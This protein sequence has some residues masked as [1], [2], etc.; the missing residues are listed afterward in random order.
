MTRLRVF[1]VALNESLQRY[2]AR[3]TEEALGIA[4]A[5]YFK[6]FSKFPHLLNPIAS[7]SVIEETDGEG[8]KHV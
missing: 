1:Y 6:K 5:A 2:E 4:V 3:N 8:V 7:C